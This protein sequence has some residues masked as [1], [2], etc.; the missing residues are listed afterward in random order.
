MN[1]ITPL[2]R[3]RPKP[4]RLTPE[5]APFQEDLEALIAEPP[6]PLLRGAHWLLALLF[7]CLL[8][9]AAVM[10][11]DVVVTAPGRLMPDTPP[12][13][14]QPME[15]AVLRELL[16]RPGEVVA[17]GAVLARLDPTFAEADRAALANQ[18]ASLAAQLARVEAELD[19]R[20]PPAATQPEEALQSVLLGQRQ[21][22]QASRL[23]AHAE[24]IAAL[25]A[26]L[27][28]NLAQQ[29]ALRQQAALAREVEA[30]RQRLMEGQIGSRLNLLAA[31]SQRLEADK[32]LET[33]EGREAELRHDL[34][35]REA[36]REA[37]A[38]DW[39]RQLLE[40]AVRL[41]GE[42]AR[43]T[44]SLAKAERLAALTT[45]VAPADGVVL[46][47]ARRSAG[48]VL[49][50]AEP[51]VTLAPSEAPLVAEIMLRSAD[52]GRLRPGDPVVLKVD[53]FPFQRH[54]PL[55]GTLR[56]V[57][58][59]SFNPL[60]PSAEPNLAAGGAAH[61]GQVR[62]EPGSTLPLVPGMTLA[63]E[64]HVGQRSVLGYFLAPLLRGLRES[65]R[66]P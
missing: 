30:L 66:E 53:A 62:I 41:R 34:A 39:R 15:R 21:A 42:L 27:A 11:L 26:G 54:G 59:D 52:I 31:R 56:A 25:Q 12:L 1:A 2:R 7:V 3:L 16:V 24:A 43:A 29:G 28:S 13:V 14:V 46:E 55:H 6:P 33:A 18:R 17:R 19:G 50:E 10:R 9:A 5:A 47:V 20:A 61:R 63:A 23:R 38:Q 65:L 32:A 40:D 22:L 64:I 58:Q 51:L 44:E 57:G 36:E 45:L 8:A 37:F 60:Q 49:R 35:A 48:S 4:R